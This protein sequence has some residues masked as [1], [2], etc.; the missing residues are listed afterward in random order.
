M[1]DPVT[2]VLVYF[3]G[4][5]LWV[6]LFFHILLNVFAGFVLLHNLIRKTLPL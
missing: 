3:H 6:Y 2:N 4:P 5:A 1:V